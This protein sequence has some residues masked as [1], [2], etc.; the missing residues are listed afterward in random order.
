MSQ[1]SQNRSLIIAGNWKM[2]FGPRETEAFFEELSGRW[3]EFVSSDTDQLLQTSALRVLIFAPSLSLEKARMCTQNSLPVPVFIGAQNA[4]WE[5]KGAFTGEISAEMLQ[6]LGIHHVLIGHSERRQYFGETDET[7]G[8]RT[9]SLLK[10]GLH[11]MTCIGETQEERES[12]KTEEVLAQQLRGFLTPET[13]P[14]LNGTLTLAYEP[15]WAIGTGL[16]A[17][18]EQAEETHQFIRK[19]LWDEYGIEASGRTPILYGGSMKPENAPQLLSQPNVDGG[20]IGGA[21]LKAESF[22]QL[23]E[24]AGAH[25]Q[26]QPSK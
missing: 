9:H 19:H 5:S 1:S 8:K 26:A 12:G 11:V 25:L 6:Q 17:T 2:N 7:V 24:A 16:T 13:A 22:L 3:K 23:I 21:S 4:H 14:Y 18:P 10:Q 20:L 15:V